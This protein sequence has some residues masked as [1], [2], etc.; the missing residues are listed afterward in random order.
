VQAPAS[1]RLCGLATP[2]RWRCFCRSSAH[3][4]FA[5]PGAAVSATGSDAGACV[6]VGTGAALEIFDCGGLLCGRIAWLRKARD[7]AGRPV[8]DDEN[9]DPAFRQRPL[10]GLTVLHGLRPA[11]PDRWN[12]GSLYNPDD[13]QTYRVSAKLRSADVLVARTYVGVPLFG[14]TKTLQW[15]AGLGLDGRCWR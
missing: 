4:F 13:G 11:G 5:V 2:C 12:S 10:C 9:P 14:E 3:R 6:V 1:A 8:Q 7:S 15:I